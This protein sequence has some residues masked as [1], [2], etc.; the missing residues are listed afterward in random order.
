MA[1]FAMIKANVRATVENVLGC[2]NLKD[3][4]IY[5]L[6]V[7]A[8]YPAKARELLA[9]KEFY[10]RALCATNSRLVFDIGAC[11]GAKTAIFYELAQM[12]VAVEPG[13]A[14]SVLRERFAHK[15]RVTVVSA[16]VGA[17]EGV[18]LLHV[19]G[20]GGGGFDTIS[21]KWT[22]T[23]AHSLDGRDRP[24]MLPSK[25]MRVP[26]TTL[27]KLIAEYGLPSY[28]KIDIEGAEL[29]AIRGLS[30]KI[31]LVS[32][33]C[34]LPVFKRE[35]LEIIALLSARDSGAR[36]NFSI[37]EP[38]LEFKSDE[39]LSAEDITGIVEREEFGFME[40]YCRSS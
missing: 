2:H 15:P 26:I 30:R 31:S 11:G 38:P 33:E 28:I 8:R 24:E 23:L 18:G 9:E 3:T 37:T 34:N 32:V 4:S 14:E 19:Y 17:N 5:N 39:W 22:E 21:Q 25:T 13:P 1:D 20:E 7:R 36:F 40:I 29:D 35:T 27:D 10:R 12:I 16:A 6:Y